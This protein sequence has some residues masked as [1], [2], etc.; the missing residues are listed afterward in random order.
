MPGWSRDS[1]KWGWSGA[2]AER[3]QNSTCHVWGQRYKVFWGWGWERSQKLGRAQGYSFGSNGRWTG[4]NGSRSHALTI[5]APS[6][7]L[8]NISHQATAFLSA[9]KI[10][11][12]VVHFMHTQKNKAQRREAFF[13]RL[14]CH[15]FKWQSKWGKRLTIGESGQ[16]MH[17]S[18]LYSSYPY[19][20]SI[21]LRLFPD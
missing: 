4:S 15:L 14:K 3:Q 21:N 7:S 10:I 17:G 5:G 20:F 19:S 11:H 2:K 13:P 8:S 18:S 16:R 1:R 12:P 9:L 6:H